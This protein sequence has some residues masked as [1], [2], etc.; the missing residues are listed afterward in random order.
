[1][2]TDW[3]S[4]IPAHKD[5]VE[6]HLLN[7]FQSELKDAQIFEEVTQLYDQHCGDPEW[8]SYKLRSMFRIKGSSKDIAIQASMRAAMANELRR[9]K[10]YDDDTVFKISSGIDGKV[11][12]N[13]VEKDSMSGEGH[14][15]QY[16]PDSP[17]P[18]VLQA[19]VQQLAESAKVR[20]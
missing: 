2:A 19:K 3:P 4:S 6:K 16:Y 11:W 17:T 14:Q 9:R 18:E 7:L 20:A 13:G 10:L 1:M 15:D 5:P 8:T 12:V